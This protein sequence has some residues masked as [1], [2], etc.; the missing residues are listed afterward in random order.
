M[1]AGVIDERDMRFPRPGLPSC[2]GRGLVLSRGGWSAG[3]GWA[4]SL[5]SLQMGAPF[6]IVL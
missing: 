5:A 2:R 4:H 1:G 3:R 6:L